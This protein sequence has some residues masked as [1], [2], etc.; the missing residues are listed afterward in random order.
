M[1][2]KGI[3]KEGDVLD[4]AAKYELIRKAGAFYSYGETKLGQGRE[5]SKMTL[6]ADK[7]LMDALEKEI[8]KTVAACRA[9]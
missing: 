5:N 3:S 7:K 9:E 2:N 4:L 1:Y 8:K 6:A